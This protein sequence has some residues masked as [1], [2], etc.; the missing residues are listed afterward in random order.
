MRIAIALIV[1]PILFAGCTPN[2]P[3]RPDFGTSALAPSGDA[4]PEDCA[5][6]LL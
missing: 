3:A 6:Q 4:P 1:L 5:V 2:I